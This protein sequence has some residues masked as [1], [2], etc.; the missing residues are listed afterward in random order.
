M[1]KNIV[2]DL[3]DENS[4]Y[5]FRNESHLVYT[6]FIVKNDLEVIILLFSF[7][8]TKPIL[9]IFPAEDTTQGFTHA[10]PSLPFWSNKIKEQFLSPIFFQSI[11]YHMQ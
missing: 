8:A 10:R 7:P 2:F 4:R 6:G 11:V 9:F 5:I 1:I 3:E